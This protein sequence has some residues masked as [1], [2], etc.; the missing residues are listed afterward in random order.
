[1]LD[2]DRAHRLHVR[3]RF[4]LFEFLLNPTQ[5]NPHMMWVTWPDPHK[6]HPV[7]STHS[8]RSDHLTQLIEVWPKFNPFQ[9]L[10][11][12]LKQVQSTKILIHQTILNQADH[13]LIHL[14]GL[15][16]LCRLLGS[17]PP[18]CLLQVRFIYNLGINCV[19]LNVWFV[20]EKCI[21]F[22]HSKIF[23]N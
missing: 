15:C 18:G 9:E 17:T 10:N 20:L 6:P 16:R 23:F 4:D 2:S 5:P 12:S 22:W 13:N 14:N 3:S 1:M 7:W 11:C 21:N 8:D 19:M